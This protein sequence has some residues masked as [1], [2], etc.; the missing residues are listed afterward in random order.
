M[1]NCCWWFCGRLSFVGWSMEHPPNKHD[2]SIIPNG[3]WLRV[4]DLWFGMYLW[5]TT[6]HFEISKRRNFHRGQ[7]LSG[8]DGMCWVWGLTREWTESRSSPSL[9]H[10]HILFDNSPVLGLDDVRLVSC[11]MKVE[12]TNTQ[13]ESLQT[14]SWGTGI[15]CMAVLKFPGH[16][17]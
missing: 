14:R 4:H 15:R 6:Q 13:V 17:K 9:P 3:L 16:K 10:L 8:C 7:I 1:Q 12:R 11:G 5:H 2:Y